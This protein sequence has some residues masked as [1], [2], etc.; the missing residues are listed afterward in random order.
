MNISSG[1]VAGR[2]ASGENATLKS[3]SIGAALPNSTGTRD[4]LIVGGNLNYSSGSVANGSIVYGGTAAL[5]SVSIPR[6]TARRVVNP[7]A[8]ASTQSYIQG[9]ATRWASLPA[10]GSTVVK[11]G[12]KTVAITL[13]GSNS[14]QNVFA[15]N[16]ADLAKAGSLN[17]SVPSG[18]IAII[19]VNGT[20]DKL[21]SFTIKLGGADSQHI[22]WNFF[23][24][25]SLALS[26]VSVP[27]TIWA[28]QAAVTFSSSP[29]N[30]SLV[31]ASLT[32]SSS[33]FTIARFVGPLP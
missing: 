24:A 32:S 17:I 30:G 22:V 18:S 23:A 25:T 12:G 4:D 2:A 21:Q 15:L 8:T 33:G 1:S 16:G 13:S 14:A 9:V 3:L 31:A 5:S 6:G 26:S 27:G 20:V 11:S 10:N 7:L 28:P 29:L 19:N